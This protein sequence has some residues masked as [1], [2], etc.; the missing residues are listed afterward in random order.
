YM[1]LAAIVLILA[2]GDWRARVCLT[3]AIAAFALM[4]ATNLL[5]LILFTIGVA[6]WRLLARTASAPSWEIVKCLAA[7]VVMVLA[8]NFAYGW[9]AA[10]VAGAPIQSPP[11]LTARMIADGPGEALLQARCDDTQA[12][13][14]ACA[15]K[16]ARFA[17][18]NDVLWGSN[19]RS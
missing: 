5:L 2:P 17:D 13:Y 19:P 11:Y 1:I 14:A 10:K 7:A 18:E 16:G 15:L 9:I 3:L 4:H 6:G 8:F 12:P